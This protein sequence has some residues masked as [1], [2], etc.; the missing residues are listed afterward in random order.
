MRDGVN[1]IDK[2][3]FLT[4]Y[5]KARTEAM[6]PAIARSGFAATGLIPFNPE[7]VLEK[8]NTQIRTPTPPPAPLPPQQWTPETPQHPEAVDLQAKSIKESLHRRMYPNIPSSPTESA[9]QQLVKCAKIAMQTNTV[10]A[11]E[12]RQLRAE[13]ARQKRKRAI[14]RSFIQSGGVLTVQQGI[15]LVET[16]ENR[17]VE[18]EAEP[19]MAPQPRAI[20]MCSVCRSI[21]HTARTC[22]MRIR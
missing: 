7:R 17:P 12:N 9:F 1:H 6:T 11:E 22:S 2:P 21:E 8:L 3:D 4:A 16:A 15:E 14:K 19:S 5:H 10:L 20:R 13:N 18:G